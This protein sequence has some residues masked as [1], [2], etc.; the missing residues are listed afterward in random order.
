MEFHAERHGHGVLQLGSAH[1]D[2][3]GEFVAL[4][5][6]ALA[7]IVD[8]PDKPAQ[9]DVERQAQGGG[10]GVVGGLGA[11]DVVVGMAI[12]VFA[13][14]VAHYFQGSVGD[15]LV[16]VHVGGGARSALDD[17]HGELVQ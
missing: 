11:V 8:I 9:L 4:G 3:M 10:I 17:V 16:G 7:Q 5:R 14:L 2:H 15:Y 6:E 1:L 13:F 12:L